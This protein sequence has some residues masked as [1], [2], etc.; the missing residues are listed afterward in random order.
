MNQSFSTKIPYLVPN[1]SEGAMHGWLILQGYG[2]E[3]GGTN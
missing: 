2:K 1:L 3:G